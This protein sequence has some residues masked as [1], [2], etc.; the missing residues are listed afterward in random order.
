[1]LFRSSNVEMMSAI[2]KELP[3]RSRVKWAMAL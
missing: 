1:M 2:L 3:S